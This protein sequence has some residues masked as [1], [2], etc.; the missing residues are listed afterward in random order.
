M[1]NPGDVVLGRCV[2]HLLDGRA[3]DLSGLTAA[4]AIARIRSL[5]ITP[6]DVRETRHTLP[7]G[8]D[9]ERR[10]ARS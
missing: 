9:A 3:I 4:A 10:E 8:R 5:G 2:I 1:A 6:A 7:E